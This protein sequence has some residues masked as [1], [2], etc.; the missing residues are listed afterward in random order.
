MI[1]MN[2]DAAAEII[3]GTAA[4]NPEAAAE[5]VQ[6]MMS[7]N[8]EAAVE[9][10]AHGPLA[11]GG[12][13]LGLGIEIAKNVGDAFGIPRSSGI[14]PND[15]LNEMRRQTERDA[16]SVFFSCNDDIMD[17]NYDADVEE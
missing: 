4:S 9:M 6:E 2:P 11:K 8:P 3:A 13:M 17:S 12:A 5:I 14:Y 16:R 15:Q 1:A 7:A 10:L